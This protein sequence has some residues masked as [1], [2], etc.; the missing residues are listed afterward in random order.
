MNEREKA[1]A[2]LR[3]FADWCEANPEFPASKIGTTI[4]IHCATAEEFKSVAAILRNGSTVEHPIAKDAQGDWYMH[5]RRFGVIDVQAYTRRSNVCE[6]VVTTRELP[7]EIIPAR[8][9]EPE[10]HLP[11]RTEEVVSWKCPPS[12]F[13]ESA[14][15]EEISAELDTLEKEVIA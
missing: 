13:E 10:Q 4:L 9:A 12:I 14:R 1:I 7:A 11:A 6:R 8:P 2:G 5:T 15:R 3:E